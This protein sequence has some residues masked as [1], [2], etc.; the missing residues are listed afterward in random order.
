MP[1]APQT[2]YPPDLADDAPETVELA[3]VVDAVVT[4]CDDGACPATP[5]ARRIATPFPDP[6]GRPLE[7]VR[8]IRD[9][10]DAAVQDLVAELDGSVAASTR[11]ARRR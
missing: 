5:G 4:V 11:G 3:D 2:P 6:F 7:E 9:A 1:D 8:P 10:I